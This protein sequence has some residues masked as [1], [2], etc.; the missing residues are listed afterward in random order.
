MSRSLICGCSITQNNGLWMQE[1]QPQVQ[2]LIEAVRT[3]QQTTASVRRLLQSAEQQG[4]NASSLLP[5][6]LRP[7]RKPSAEQKQVQ[8]LQRQLADQQD[9]CTRLQRLKTHAVT[10]F[11]EVRCCMSNLVVPLSPPHGLANP[12]YCCLQNNHQVQT[13]A[14]YFPLMAFLQQATATCIFLSS[15]R[16]RG[17]NRQ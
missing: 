6:H 16:I 13:R 2:K 12:I 11:S 5:A 14:N 3:E 15:G 9:N 7:K 10:S 17:V 1:T 8:A 4:F